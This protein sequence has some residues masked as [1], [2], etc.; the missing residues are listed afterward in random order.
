[1]LVVICVLLKIE[2]IKKELQY[3]GSTDNKVK[4]A[5]LVNRTDGISSGL[6]R[7][8][9]DPEFRLGPQCKGLV[10]DPVLRLILQLQIEI[11]DQ[12]RKNKTKPSV[13]QPT[14]VI[15]IGKESQVLE[16]TN[17]CPTQFRGPRLKGL[18]AALSSAANVSS[19]SHLSGAKCVALTKCLG[20]LWITQWFTPTIV[21]PGIL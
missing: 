7:R 11:P 20:D 1:M 2:Q 17:L 8:E 19:P 6:P 13:C 9:Y 16:R 21:S 10:D 3:I 14:Q 4:A 18:K 12:P 5:R 15:R